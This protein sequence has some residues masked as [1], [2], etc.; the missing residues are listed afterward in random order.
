MGEEEADC[1]YFP[2]GGNVNRIL[3]RAPMSFSIVSLLL[4]SANIALEDGR[5]MLIFKQRD[6]FFL[7]EDIV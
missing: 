6:I 5:T 2:A 4:I 3:L 1:Q 7:I